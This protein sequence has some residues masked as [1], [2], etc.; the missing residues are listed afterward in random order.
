M[1]EV[2]P[3]P[4][5]RHTVTPHLVVQ[6]AAQ[7]IEFYKTAFAAEEI[8]RMPAPDGEF[9]MHAE[10]KIGDSIVMLCDELPGMDRCLSPKSLGGTSV[11][12]HIWSEDVDALYERAL[13]AGA[14]AS[15]PLADMFWGDRYGKVT[16]PF[17]HEWSMATHKQDLTPEEMGKAAE[18]FFSQEGP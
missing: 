8:A 3:I 9:L 14:A 16:D 2:Q 11:T 10:V 1:G 5:G 17:G 4:K 7:A 15:M 18:E 12:V 6:N 13:K